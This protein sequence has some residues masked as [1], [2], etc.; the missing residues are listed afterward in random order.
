MTGKMRLIPF[1][2]I[3]VFSMICI[4]CAHAKR[5]KPGPHFVWIKAHT[6]PAGHTIPGHWKYNGPS[7]KG[8]IWVQGHPNEAGNWV[9]GH[10]KKLTPPKKAANWVPGHYGPRG[11]WISGHWR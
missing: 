4:S 7:V 6:A 5:P 10:W 2:I 11:K 8:K 1:M 9:E 3:P